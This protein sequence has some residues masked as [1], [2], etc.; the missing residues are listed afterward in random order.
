MRECRRTRVQFPAAPPFYQ[1]K[2]NE[3][4]PRQHHVST[5]DASL[6]GVAFIRE[7]TRRDGTP[8]FSVT[9]L[10]GGRG[11]RQSSTSF[12]ERG[13]AEKF[14]ALVDAF[15]PEQALAKAGISDTAQAMSALTVSDEHTAS[16]KAKVIQPAWV[17]ALHWTNA[18]AMVLMI[19]R[20]V[21]ASMRELEGKAG[22]LP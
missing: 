6:P 7:R 20:R 16:T 1:G 21:R 4:R 14:C 10:V 22:A 2:Q 8:Y 12:P 17:R 19:T 3:Y 18:F 11:S 5:T 9:Y 13:Q 15:G